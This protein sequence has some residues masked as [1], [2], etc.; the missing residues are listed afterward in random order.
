M[1]AGWPRSSTS[2]ASGKLP[3]QLCRR[4]NLG[5]RPVGRNG[6]APTMKTNDPAVRE[7]FILGAAEAVES[8]S[9]YLCPAQ[10]NELRT[11][12]ESYMSGTKEIRLRHPI[13][14]VD[15]RKLV[16][17]SPRNHR[18]FG[19][20]FRGLKSA[21]ARLLTAFAY[22]TASEW[23]AAWRT[24]VITL[25]SKPRSYAHKDRGLGEGWSPSG[26]SRVTNCGHGP[27][28]A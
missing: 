3:S 26:T 21:D 20:G 22:V 25:S 5:A 16:K 11:G 17:P 10:V 9:L 18:D 8:A 14:G 2:T 6:Y 15:A 12:L 23:S 13:C 4:T 28:R 27:E 19:Q 24:G 7:A 1:A